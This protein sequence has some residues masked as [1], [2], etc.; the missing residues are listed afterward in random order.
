[1]CTV[2]YSQYKLSFD[3]TES[4]IDYYYIKVISFRD[5][6]PQFK[7]SNAASVPEPSSPGDDYN[8]QSIFVGRSK[9]WPYFASYM[10]LLSSS[11]CST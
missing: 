2:Q 5:R 10:F 11:S 7:E 6:I 4:R 1:M 9:F 3:Q 8:N